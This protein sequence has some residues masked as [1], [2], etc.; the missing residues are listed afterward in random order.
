MADERKF[1]D[2][3]SLGPVVRAAFGKDRTLC[4]AVRLA[5]GSKK[6]AYRLTMDDDA[7]ALAYVWDDSEDYWQGVLPEGAADPA[8]PFSHASGL[9]FFE[10]AARWPEVVQGRR[11]LHAGS[12]GWIDRQE[13]F[14]Q[15]FEW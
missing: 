11:A 14:F 7:T 12:T 6:G 5:G 3:A 1:A 2:A 10:A 15:R 13:A 8:D 4:T 9:A